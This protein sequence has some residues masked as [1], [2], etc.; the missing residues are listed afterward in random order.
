MPA[1]SE[2]VL[3]F[4][5]PESAR[6]PDEAAL[7]AAFAAR[8]AEMG[9]PWL[10]AFLPDELV[11]KLRAMGFSRVAH[12]YLHEDSSAAAQA[13]DG[14]LRGRGRASAERR[15]GAAAA[16]SFED[17][18]SGFEE[19]SNVPKTRVGPGGTRSL[20]TTVR[21][22]GHEFS[23]GAPAAPPGHARPYLFPDRRLTQATSHT[24]GA[25]AAGFVASPALARRPPWG[26]WRRV[27]GVT[28]SSVTRGAR[29]ATTLPRIADRAR[30][31]GAPGRRLTRTEP[32]QN[33]HQ[34][35]H[36]TGGARRGR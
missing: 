15:S 17:G 7:V 32:V 2:I 35:R 11:A 23:G 33:R 13:C 14:V 26:R 34:N 22:F 24:P 30:S 16:Q 6:P 27:T 20:S 28:R 5:L 29:V 18:R 1:S 4:V 36:H 25:L 3:S 8:S 19:H 9:E 21:Q 31:V 10:T 12:L